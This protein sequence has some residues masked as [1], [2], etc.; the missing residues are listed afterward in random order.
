MFLAATN[1]LKK[2]YSPKTI[3]KLQHFFEL[4]KY[5]C[6]KNLKKGFPTIEEAH[7]PIQ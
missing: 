1:T 7:F 2:T 4:T 3:A 6:Q 5:F